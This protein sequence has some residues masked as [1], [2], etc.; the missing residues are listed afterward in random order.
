VKEI[1]SAY[2]ERLATEK[3]DVGF[4]VNRVSKGKADSTAQ[5]Q[6]TV[7]FSNPLTYELTLY[8]EA[9]FLISKLKLPILFSLLLIGITIAS[10]V[11][12]YRSLIKQ[13]RLAQI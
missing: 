6:V 10:F 1:D 5:N 2:T 3:L 4:A 12:L 11:A 8:N 7:G 13:H 9:G